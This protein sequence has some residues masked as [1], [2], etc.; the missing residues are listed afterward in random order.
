ME[1][2]RQP[3][4]TGQLATGRPPRLAHRRRTGPPVVFLDKDGTL[5]ENVPYNVDPAQIRLGPGARV[6][7]TALHRAGYRLVVVTNQSGI[8]RG[9]F[10][11][12]DL[13]GVERR[14]RELLDDFGVPLD[15]W[16]VCPHHPDGI[17]EFAIRCDCRKPASGLLRR[18]ARDLAVPLRSSWLVGDILDDV[19][20]GRS[21]GCRTVLLDR[22]GETEWH[23]SAPRTPDHVARDLAEAADIILSTDADPDAV[24][25]DGRSA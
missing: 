10:G 2:A 25:P 14:V 19:E 4:T 13:R 7:L 24:A 5:V 16:Y 9:R 11:F 12:A 21:A 22:G 3:A 8:A 23:L 6:G 1:A 15:G 17:N 18:A 20:A